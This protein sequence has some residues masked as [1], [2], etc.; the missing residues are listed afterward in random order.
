MTFKGHN[1]GETL[2]TH[3]HIRVQCNIFFSQK[4]FLMTFCNL[5][6]EYFKYILRIFYNKQS[7]KSLLKVHFGSLFYECIHKNFGVCYLKTIWF[8]YSKKVAYEGK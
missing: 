2:K 7:P 4:D 8:R 1:L 6:M 5:Q 3:I